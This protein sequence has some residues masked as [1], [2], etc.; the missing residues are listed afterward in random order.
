VLAGAA[1]LA[2]A[3]LAIASSGPT[4][5]HLGKTSFGP[6]VAERLQNG[7]HDPIYMSTHDLRDKSRCFGTCT[8]TFKP[9][10]MHPREDG[11]EP[12]GGVRAWNGVKQKLL[13]SISRGHGI[14]QV[15]YNHHP[16]YTATT[17]KPGTAAQDGCKVARGRWYVLSKQGKPDKRWNCQFY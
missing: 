17:D 15:T 9:V 10:T 7:H 1:A 12:G 3:G 6:Y 13:G 8:L 14:R 16:L 5:I 2:L 11:G 4:N